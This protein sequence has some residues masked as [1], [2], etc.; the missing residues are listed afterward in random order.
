MDKRKIRA[1]VMDVD[2]TLTDGGIYTGSNGEVMKKFYVRDG[3][4]IKHMLPEQ[5]IIP[6]IITGRSS[7]IVSLRCKELDITHVVQGSHEKLT[8]LKRI[9]EAE[10]I[11]PEE[12]AYIGDD[13]NDLE[14]MEYAGVT[15][16]PCD[17]VE[18]VKKTVDYISPFAGGNGAVRSFIEWIINDERNT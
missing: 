3:L 11:S 4:A 5:E 14:C 1:L 18:K 8:D 2:G 10:G 16:C 9:L 15:G 6:V 17:A 7:E 12:T 13:I